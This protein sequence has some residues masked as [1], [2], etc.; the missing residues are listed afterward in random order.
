MKLSSQL[1]AGGLC[2]MSSTS[3]F[4]PLPSTR[5]AIRMHG[6]LDDLS[7]ELNA[8]DPNPNPEEESR[9][10]TKATTSEVDRYGVSDWSKFV[11]FDVR[12]FSSFYLLVL[13]ECLVDTL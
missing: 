10:V 5:P 11:D 7:G 9:E 3:A 4:Q 12:R 13:L 8:A 2:L 1:V 6:Y